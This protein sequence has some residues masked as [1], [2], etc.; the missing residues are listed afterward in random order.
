MGRHRA[1]GS[2]SRR[3]V[4]GWPIAV[5]GLVLLVVV[6]WLGWSWLGGLLER[7]AAAEAGTCVDGEATLTVAVTPGVAEPVRRAAS[8]WA[9]KRPVIQDH[10]VTVRVTEAE[11]KAVLDG[12]TGTWDEAKLGPRPDAWLPDSTLWVDRLA[13]QD[14]NA[15]ATQP[16]SVGTSPVLLAVPDA[17]AQPLVGG[18]KD[19]FRWADLPGLTAAPDGW[20]RFGK[21]EWGRFTVAVP[22][23]AANPASLFA[24][25]AALAGAGPNAAGPLTADVLGS[26]PV[27]DALSQLAKAQPAEVPGTTRDALV[28]LAEQKDMAA[29]PFVA[30][31]AT[32]IDLYRRN[33]GADGAPRPS[34]PLIGLLAD[35]PSPVADFPFVGLASSGGQ[36]DEVQLRAAQKFREFLRED[37]QQRLFASAGLRVRATAD[38]PTSSPG[39]RWQPLGT[40][41]PALP[42]DV[43]EQLPKS[44]AETATH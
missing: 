33:I 44:W 17:G 38:H 13:A 27:S 28:K 4:A 41:V 34:M 1:L 5:L 39:L 7:R 35:G 30:V 11:P 37:A 43:A 20:N 22:D 10:C 14:G 36:D 3:G 32:E 29:T 40:Q 12:F 19:R 16:E 31:P 2:A 6:G 25:G 21:P 42:R 26:Q 9:T 15:V 24:V 8:E 23:P 18:D